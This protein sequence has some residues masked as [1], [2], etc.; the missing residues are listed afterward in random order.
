M[1]SVSYLNTYNWRI[2][3]ETKDYI[4]DDINPIFIKPILF[5][6]YKSSTISKYIIKLNFRNCVSGKVCR[7]LQCLQKKLSEKAVNK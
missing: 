7:T 4:P 5:V 1:V 2:I 6:Y 3:K